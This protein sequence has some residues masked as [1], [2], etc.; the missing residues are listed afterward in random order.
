LLD[1]S[2]LGVQASE[3]RHLC[4][5]NN[6]Y[7]KGFCVLCEETVCSHCGFKELKHL[8]CDVS[9]I[10]CQCGHQEGKCIKC[11]KP[12]CLGCG[13]EV[14]AHERQFCN[15]Q[16]S[17]ATIGIL[18]VDH[19]CWFSN[20]S[21]KHKETIALNNFSDRKDM[22]FGTHS[23]I[24]KIEI[25]NKHK[26]IGNITKQDIIREAKLVHKAGK[27]YYIRTRASINKS[28]DEF[29]RANSSILLNPVTATDSKEQNL[30]ISPSQKEMRKLSK[31]LQE[32]GGKT[33]VI[34]AEE[35]SIRK[36][37]N[38]QNAKINFMLEKVPKKELLDNLQKV[39]VLK[40]V[41]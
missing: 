21:E 32:F 11:G 26:A 41:N 14:W 19:E 5:C 28:V 34:T 18:E 1:K 10:N 23:G 35:F 31:G 25:D 39:L 27:N 3:L 33:R 15:K 16:E 38:V 37:N 36:I 30:I 24:L 12:V 7:T 22:K 40:T 2:L 29:T 6:G 8:D 17:T 13:K 20:V 4:A 9:C